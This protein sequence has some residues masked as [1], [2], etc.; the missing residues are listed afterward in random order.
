MLVNTMSTE[1]IYLFLG[2]GS[3]KTGKKALIR[4]KILKLMFHGVL[5]ENTEIISGAYH[6]SIYD[7]N[8][9]KLKKIV[10]DYDIKLIC[11]GDKD[12]TNEYDFYLTQNFLA[13]EALIRDVEYLDE[14]IKNDFV[15]LLFDNK[16]LCVMPWIGIHQDGNKVDSCCIQITDQNYDVAVVKKN[17]L[18]NKKPKEC[19]ECYLIEDGNSI[20]NRV[21][22]S[23]EWSQRL[24]IKTIEDLN[25]SNK[26][27][28]FDFR[29]DNTC[30]LMCRTCNPQ[31]S[32]LIEKEYSK[33]GLY[34]GIPINKKTSFFNDDQLKN[35]KRFYFAGGEP[36]WHP[37]F[38]KTL[39][40]L[41][42]LG[43]LDADIQ[44]NTN[45]AKIP[46]KVID[47][48]KKFSNLFFIVSFDG[49]ED[50][51]TYIRWPNKWDLF[52]ENVKILSEL[53]EKP[54]QFNC[55]I[56]LYNITNCYSMLKW[57]EDNYENSVLSFT[58]L[59]YPVFQQAKFFPDK[60]LALSEIEKLKTLKRFFNDEVF[61]S[62]V[63]LLENLIKVQELDTK[64][65]E[66]FFKFNDLLDTS[67][68]CKLSD[69]IPELDKCRQYI[70][71]QI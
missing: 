19:R 50:K 10:D 11:L 63:A 6:T 71:N 25:N 60:A 35:G 54:L 62:K 21:L 44:I 38:L 43:L 8:F 61:V 45:A 18:D 40:Q 27:E 33:I 9:F 39:E 36:L 1:K 48:F 23:S 22:L 15:K 26:I 3:E 67:R 24:N 56:S 53:S 31:N 2:N 57:I 16:S 37:D 65:L 7:I 68:N 14:S 17:M 49:F 41:E 42:G 55:V 59:T 69:Y 70:T 64:T 20:S 30:N 4:S 5:D 32:S 13:E 28:Y 51:L 46:K 66:E 29:L 58:I 52:C 34:T 12:Y 47:I